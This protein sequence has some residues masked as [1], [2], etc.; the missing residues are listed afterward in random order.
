MISALSSAVLCCN[1]R[2]VQEEEEDDDEGKNAA[3]AS[4]KKKGKSGKAEAAA[5][6]DKLSTGGKWTPYGNSSEA[7]IVVAAGKIGLW[8]ED[9]E[10][11][12]PRVFEVPFSSSRKVCIFIFSRHVFFSFSSHIPYPPSPSSTR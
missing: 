4:K 6:A 9:L 12:M 7:P 8:S 10:R 5:A 1:T 3:A 11:T 2:V